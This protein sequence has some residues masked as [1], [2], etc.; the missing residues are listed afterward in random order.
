MSKIDPDYASGNI[1]AHYLPSSSTMDKLNGI[2]SDF[3]F[4][5]EDTLLKP[6]D[7]VKSETGFYSKTRPE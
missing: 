2:D 4:K 3:I 5:K 7:Y 1:L 6:I